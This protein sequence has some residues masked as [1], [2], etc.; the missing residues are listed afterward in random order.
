MSDTFERYGHSTWKRSNSGRE[1]GDRVDRVYRTGCGTRRRS[2][3]RA[4][5]ERE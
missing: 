1:W 4:L 2:L 5:M 3:P